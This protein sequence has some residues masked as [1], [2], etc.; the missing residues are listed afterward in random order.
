M[1]EGGLKVSKP[2]PQDDKVYAYIQENVVA[3]LGNPIVISVVQVSVNVCGA[4]NSSFRVAESAEKRR[5]VCLGIA[6]FKFEGP[7]GRHT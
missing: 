3:F 7:S 4:A 2:S 6:Q 1:K 5:L